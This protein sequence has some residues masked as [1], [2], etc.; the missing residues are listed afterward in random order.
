MTRSLNQQGK[1][2]KE[3]SIQIKNDV[4]H[5]TV[6][7]SDPTLIQQLS[8]FFKEVIDNMADTE[9]TLILNENDPLEASSFLNELIGIS[10]DATKKRSTVWKTSW[11][12]LSTKWM[13]N[14]YVE[15]YADIGSKH[16]IK[17]LNAAKPQKYCN[18]KIHIGAIGID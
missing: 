10:M 6:F 13:V 15:M 7:L 3:I 9:T 8:D 2:N 4:T 1:V 12:K 5:V 11:A 16:I 17:M 18:L 14:S